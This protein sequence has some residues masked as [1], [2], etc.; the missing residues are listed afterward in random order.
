MEEEGRIFEEGQIKD[1]DELIAWA[2]LDIKQSEKVKKKSKKPTIKGRCTVE[3]AL[4][5][6]KPNCSDSNL[7]SLEV[8]SR[9]NRWYERA[10]A[11]ALGGI[12]DD[13][14]SYESYS[15]SESDEMPKDMAMLKKGKSLDAID[16]GLG[17]FTPDDLLDKWMKQK[18]N[19]L[20]AEERGRSASETSV[21]PIT[22]EESDS[23]LLS[24]GKDD[25]QL[26]GFAP[27]E[28]QTTSTPLVI[29]RIIVSQPSTDESR[30]RNETNETLIGNL[31]NQPI[32]YIPNLKDDEDSKTTVIYEEENIASSKGRNR[33]RSRSELNTGISFDERDEAAWKAVEK[34]AERRAKSFVSLQRRASLEAT[35]RKEHRERLLDTSERRSQRPRSLVLSSDARDESSGIGEVIKDRPIM[36]DPGSKH[37]DANANICQRGKKHDKGKKLSKFP[38]KLFVLLIS[39]PLILIKTSYSKWAAE[40]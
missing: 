6:I 31:P 34:V 4:N 32:F 26:E 14:E 28:E 19:S 18:K 7:K 2:K 3:S 39:K 22:P 17:C 30:D 37:I 1:I 24:V 20:R 16:L 15:G 23:S 5:K 38:G 35:V 11:M 12:E 27:T 13:K 8:T 25:V 33:P 10:S 29:N 21:E 9:L 40:L 36:H